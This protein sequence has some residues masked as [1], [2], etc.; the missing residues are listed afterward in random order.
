M[1]AGMLVRRHR[2]SLQTHS[3]ARYPRATL[4]ALSLSLALSVA[5]MMN[6]NRVADVIPLSTT[7]GLIAPLFAVFIA[8]LSIDNSR[9]TSMLRQA[10]FV[11][12]GELSY[13]VYILQIPVSL[14]VRAAFGGERAIAPAML[15][16]IYL[17]AL[18][19]LSFLVYRYYETP[20]RSGLRR[21]LS[22]EPRH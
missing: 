4:A 9:L 16:A 13:A 12:L 17:M 20:L 19:A 3:G 8:A 6:L 18:I 10:P 5:L 21:C 11:L 14:G 22:G 15:F 1:C 2:A 7:N